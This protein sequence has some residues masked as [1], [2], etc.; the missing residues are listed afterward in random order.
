MIT[1]SGSNDRYKLYYRCGG[2]VG[3]ESMIRTNFP[4][5]PT[6]IQLVGTCLKVAV[7]YEGV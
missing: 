7:C 1:H 3:I 5:N 4:F 2:S 6:A